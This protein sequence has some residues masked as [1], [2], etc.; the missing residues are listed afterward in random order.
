MLILGRGRPVRYGSRTELAALSP[1]E[2]PYFQL[3]Y[4]GRRNRY[5]WSVERE[6][7]HVGN[8]PLDDLPIDAAL[9]FVPHR[10]AAESL[11]AVSP[12]PIVVLG[13]D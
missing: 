12:W 13:S 7:R 6:W 3:R 8:L 5:D 10:N 1:A 9:V 11:L 2:R 4:S